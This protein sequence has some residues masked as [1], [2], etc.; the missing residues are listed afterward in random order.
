M[1]GLHVVEREFI[2]S[3]A[4]RTD[5]WGIDVASSEQIVGI[6]RALL[7]RNLKR[8]MARC[9]S[10]DYGSAG[11][12]RFARQIGV[13]W[14]DLGVSHSAGKGSDSYWHDECVG[15]VKEGGIAYRT[16]LD[17]DRRAVEAIEFDGFII[18]VGA[19]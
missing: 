1:G 13:A 17:W 19:E 12:N 15:A 5:R 2:E 14:L 7:R 10:D 16:N 3:T 11:R 9:A 18:I 8:M 4:G 6:G